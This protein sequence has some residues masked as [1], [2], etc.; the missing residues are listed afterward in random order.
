[1]I[2]FGQSRMH[3]RQNVHFHQSLANMCPLRESPL[4]RRNKTSERHAE[5]DVNRGREQLDA[6]VA[7]AKHTNSRRLPFASPLPARQC[8]AP[9]FGRKA[10]NVIFSAK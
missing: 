9:P 7:Q 6:R 10:C 2:S 1:M 3:S 5:G 8:Q 4:V